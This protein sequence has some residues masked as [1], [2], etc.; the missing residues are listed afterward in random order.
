MTKPNADTRC[1]RCRDGEVFCIVRDNT[2]DA[3]RLADADYEIPEDAVEAI[4]NDGVRIGIGWMIDCPTCNGSGL[5]PKGKAPT[6]G[7][8]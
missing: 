6:T 5:H 1:V 2:D 8:G 3:A 7:E 4:G